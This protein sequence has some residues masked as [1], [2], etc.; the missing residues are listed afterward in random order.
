MVKHFESLGA[1]LSTKN[2][3][4]QTLLHVAI[5]NNRYKVLIYLSSKMDMMEKD[6]NGWTPLINAVQCE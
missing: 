4:G 6:G 2:N 5:E 1:N 3:K